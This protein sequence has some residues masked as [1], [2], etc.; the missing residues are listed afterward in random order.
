MTTICATLADAVQGIGDGASI[1]V[2]G[3]GQAGM[4]G[5]LLEALLDTG[6]TGLTIIS[7][8]AGQGENPLAALFRENRV[9]RVICSYPRTSGSVWFEKRWASGDLTLD[10]VPQGTLAERMRI[11]GA[12]LG[13]VYTPT[14]Y[15]T[16]IAEGKETRVIDGRGY[17]LEAP[18][19]ADVALIRAEVGDRWG[20]LRYRATARNFNPVMAMAGRLVVAQVRRVSDEPLDPETVV[21]PGIFVDRIAVHDDR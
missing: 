2:G 10:L 19:S 4:P 16:Q 3:F 15:G 18:L 13:G 14:G 17:V 20:N 1:M 12:G 21:T 9:V 8:N 7:N 6:A 11:A 5:G